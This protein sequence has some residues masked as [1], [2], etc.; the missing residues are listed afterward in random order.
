VAG[1]FTL[2]GG[3]IG[4]ALAAA[5]GLAFLRD[6]ADGTVT[7]PDLDAAARWQSGAGLAGLALRLES[8]PAWADL[9]LPAEPMEQLRDV[10]EAAR[11]RALV[12]DEWGFGR[13]LALG[14][15][16]NVLFAG[17]SGT[18]K[19][20]AA[21][22]I[23]GELSLDLYKIDLS[24][25]VSKYIGET[26]KYLA[27]IFADAEAGSLILFF[28]EADALFGQRSEVRDAHDRYANIE[29]SYLLQKLEEHDGIVILATNLRKNM[30]EAFVRRMQF[31]V[32]FPFPAE[33]ERRRIWENIWPSEACL[34]PDL[35][36][37][38][39]ARRFELTGGN[40]RNI[41]VAAAFHAASEGSP[42][43][44]AHLL[45]ATRREYQKL[46]RVTSEEEF[47]ACGE[48]VTLTRDPGAV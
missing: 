33:R 32:D 35:D 46:G 25:V 21:Q 16:L 30:D 42:V 22:A 14:K 43:T 18:G 10:C 8:R 27:R 47:A 19:T 7:A 20:M 44:M 24:L 40:I 38:R 15:G 6:E 12:F 3:Q 1:T 23:S 17:P 13:K 26:E 45:R 5:R 36:P 37:G 4:S 39:L 11:Y 28:D 29:V 34:A 48:E 41:A 31:A 9:V 2:T